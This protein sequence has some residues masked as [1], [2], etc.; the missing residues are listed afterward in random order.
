MDRRSFIKLT[1]SVASLL[2]LPKLFT[3]EQAIAAERIEKINRTNAEWKKLLTPQQYDIL[4]RDGTER[5]FSS[6]LNGEKHSGMF[7]CIACALPLFPSTYKFDSGTGWPS[8]YDVLPGH[9][10]TRTDYKLVLPRTE[11]HCARC[12]GHHG[13]LFKDGPPP[14]GLRYCDNG[15]ALQFIPGKA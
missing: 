2:A 15:V 4:R 12:G 14:T 8:F 6:L 1:T 5:P 3:L 13:H 7:V 9:V 11:Y 10:E